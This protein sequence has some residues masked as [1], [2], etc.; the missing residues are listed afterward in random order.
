[1][2]RRPFESTLAAAIG[3]MQQRIR[4]TAPPENSRQTEDLKSF[5]YAQEM[6]TNRSLTEMFRGVARA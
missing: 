3:V 6:D 5:G 4:L 2:L 1:M